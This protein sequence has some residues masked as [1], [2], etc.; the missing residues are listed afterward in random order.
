MKNSTVP[1]FVTLVLLLQ[2]PWALQGSLATKTHYSKKKKK[3]GAGGGALL[4][5]YIVSPPQQK[6]LYETL[7]EESQVVCIPISDSWTTNI[8]V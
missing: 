4:I 3:W 6:I 7:V 8:I 2:F 1:T 5:L